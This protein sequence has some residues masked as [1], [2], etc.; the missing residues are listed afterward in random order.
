MIVVTDGER[1][2]GLGDLGAN[3]MGIPI[4]KLALYTAC[5]GIAPTACLPVTLD[6]GTDNE[7]LLDEPLYLGLPRH[8][9]RGE[10]YDELV[11]EF[12]AAA[13]GA[14]SPARWSSWRTSAT[15]TPSAC[16]RRYRDEICTF[17]DDIQGTAAVALSGLYS[18]LRLTG[19]KLADQKILFF[20]AGEAGIGIG[21]L[22]VSAM[23]EQGL[24]QEEARQRCWFMDS[25]RPGGRQPHGPGAPQEALRAQPRPPHRLPGG[26][27]GAEAHR[28]HRRLRA[29]EDLL[30]RTW[31]APW[32]ATT[33]GRSSSPSPIPPP[34]R[35]ARPR[36][37]TPGARAA[38]SSPAAAPSPPSSTRG[39]S[40]VPG[41]ANNAYIFPGVGLG[42]LACGATRV[43]DEMFAAAAKALSRHVGEADLAL[44][45]T[46]PA[47]SRIREV[48]SAIAVAVAEVAYDRGL[49]TEPR[50]GDL[51]AHVE[52]LMYWPEY[53]SYV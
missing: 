25:T 14:S 51:R 23:V 40:F 10:A 44:G 29:A 24:S 12:I 3:G 47:L 13:P 26:G 53:A 42:V 9:L 4:G 27:G 1:I 50:P 34:S 28:P 18:A 11:D 20:G 21:D 22:I 6:V 38:R 46:F 36:R 45:R 30:A 8:R 43:T 32:P 41:Q 35:S 2:L 37:P 19:R 15:T 7:R 48:S 49:A 5:A 33:S 16:W 52:K 39:E 31:Y 17:D